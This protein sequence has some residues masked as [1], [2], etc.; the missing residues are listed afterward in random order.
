MSFDEFGPIPSPAIQVR[1]ATV[2][3]SYNRPK[4]VRDCL[5]S[6]LDQHDRDWLCFVMDDGSNA[7]TRRAIQQTILASGRA[8]QFVVDFGPPA[9]PEERR[10]YLRYSRRI[11]EALSV[12]V[13]HN[14]ARYVCSVCDDDHLYPE[15]IGSRA[16][17]LDA[18]PEASVVY[19]RL[20]SVGA[21]GSWDVAVPPIPGR[22]YTRPTGP[23]IPRPPHGGAADWPED[24][25]P[26]TGRGVDEGF[27]QA[28]PMRF[29]EPHKVDHN[30]VLWRVDALQ[31]TASWQRQSM[32]PRWEFWPEQREGT[33]GDAD[34]FQRLLDR[35]H[36]FHGVDAWCVVKRYHRYSD[37]CVEH[38]PEVRE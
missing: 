37:G 9:S 14:L 8:G 1:T 22:T 17:Y 11:N 15:S 38:H 4:L 20:R 10:S 7:E 18:H 23:R 35:G 29:G 27:W 32:P 2:L 31:P 3:V 26:E 30:Q 25:D 5:A 28:A 24:I 21:G 12:I 13:Q 36:L 19:G 16:D 33:I 6:I 34:F